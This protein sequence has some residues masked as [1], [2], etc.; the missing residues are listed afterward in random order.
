MSKRSD[1]IKKIRDI[2]T[3]EGEI[4][5]AGSIKANPLNNIFTSDLCQIYE[6]F[7]F[8]GKEIPME[9]HI[10]KGSKEIF[11]QL[12]GESKFSDGEILRS[13][14]IRIIQP[15]I[16]HSV[17]LSKGAKAI[18]IVHPPEIAYMPEG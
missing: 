5:I 3:R 1:N 16:S 14:D 13:G 15:G 8:D 17:L 2:I 6:C 12:T 9:E 7:N 11:Y 10:H 4:I 18:V